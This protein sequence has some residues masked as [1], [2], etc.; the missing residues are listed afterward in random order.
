MVNNQ[1]DK[2]RI[3]K[4]YEKRL[5]NGAEHIVNNHCN[6]VYIEVSKRQVIIKSKCNVKVK[7]KV[8]M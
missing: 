3:K 2:L 5:R 8:D 7:C 6:T 1:D 4:H